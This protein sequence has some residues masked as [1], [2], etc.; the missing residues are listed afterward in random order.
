MRPTAAKADLRPF[1]MS[2]RSAASCAMRVSN[3]L[4]DSAIRSTCANCASTST[5]GPSSSM[6]ST[7]TA[8]SG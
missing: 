6:T 3:A 7:A 8:P 2:A 4:R 5:C 1:H